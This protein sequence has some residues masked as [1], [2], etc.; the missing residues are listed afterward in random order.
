[1][2]FFEGDVR[3]A[4][5][6]MG[7]PSILLPSVPGSRLCFCDRPQPF[8]K[9]VRFSLFRFDSIKK[10]EGCGLEKISFQCYTPQV[11]DYSRFSCFLFFQG[12]AISGLT[13]AA[14]TSFSAAA[15]ATAAVYNFIFLFCCWCALAVALPSP[16]SSFLPPPLSC[17]CGRLT[18]YWSFGQRLAKLRNETRAWWGVLYC[19]VVG[20]GG[21]MILA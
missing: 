21:L 18:Q 4:I 6:M 10:I 5:V 13:S 2:G 12:T 9:H 16:R 8:F 11:F 19:I 17:C 3:F 15:A 1:M 14:R 7:P 20:V